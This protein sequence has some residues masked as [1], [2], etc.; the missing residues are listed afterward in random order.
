HKAPTVSL[1]P[2]A[3]ALSDFVFVMREGQI[4]AAQVQIETRPQH[5]H[6]HGA[7]LDVPARPSFSPGTGPEDRAILGHARFPQSKIRDGFFAVLIAL[8]A[9]PRPHL[10]EVQFH[11]LAIAAAAALILLDTEIDR[12]VS[13]AIGHTAR[14]Q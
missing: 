8:H 2:S 14:D 3:L 11:E 12:T 7:A 9:L 5:F 1:D 10:F 4:L 13:G 6:A